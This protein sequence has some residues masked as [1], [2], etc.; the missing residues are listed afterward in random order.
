[1]ADSFHYISAEVAADGLVDRRLSV[2]IL[3][4]GQKLK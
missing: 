4:V 3:L 1:M 2:G